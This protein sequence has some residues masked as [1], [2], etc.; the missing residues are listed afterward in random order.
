MGSAVENEALVRRIMED[1]FNN[2]N[3]GIMDELFT[4]DY[5][6]SEAGGVRLNSLAEHI[7]D[8]TARLEGFPD[9]KFDIQQIVA[10]DND[11]VAVRYYIIGTHT[12]EFRGSK[13]TGRHV[14]RAC[15]AFFTIRDNKVS[16]GY[17]CFGGRDSFWK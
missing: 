4:Q 5:T 3:F 1:G 14:T 17:L 10:S 2:R 15:T 6:R 8:L 7:A 16:E 9:T 12:G 11:T 13:P